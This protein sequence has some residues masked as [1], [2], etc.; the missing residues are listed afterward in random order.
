MQFMTTKGAP[1]LTQQ[2]IKSNSYSVMNVRLAVQTLSSS[3]AIALRNY[4]DPETHGTAL[5]CDKVNTFFD[6]CNI[7]CKA[8]GIK[9][10]KGE[11]IPFESKDDPRLEWL[12]T[13]F[14]AYFEKWRD[15]V[16]HREGSTQK[17][18]EKMFISAQT[19]EV[20]QITVNS[21]IEI[22]RFCLDS[23]FDFV[24]TQV[25]A[26]RLGTV[27]RS[28][29][30]NGKPVRKSELVQIWLRR[31]FSTSSSFSRSGERQYCRVFTGRKR[32]HYHDVDN[33]E[34]KKRS[35]K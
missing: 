17:E 14:L 6:I 18:K 7:R 23:G 33:T 27:L 1:K 25:H 9:K 28:A 22:V 31:K 5:F 24:L 21:I 13:E 10:R 29:S 34:L 8:E 19:Y 30:L 11:M 15:S 3:V 20:L 26:G 4:F 12:K 2:H 35:Q 32:P 16:Q